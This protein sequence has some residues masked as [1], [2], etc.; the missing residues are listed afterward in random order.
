VFLGFI[1]FFWLFLEGIYIEVKVFCDYE[2]K[3]FEL[4]MNFE[5]NE[6]KVPETINPS[7]VFIGKV[8]VE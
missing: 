3:A 6:I 1:Y 4:S 8:D 2:V 7:T 5:E